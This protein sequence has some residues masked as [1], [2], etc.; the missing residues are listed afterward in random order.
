MTEATQ[1]AGE[2]YTVDTTGIGTKEGWWCL[3]ATMF[4]FAPSVFSNVYLQLNE[5]RLDPTLQD[6]SSRL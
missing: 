3:T 1:T 2:E 5:I 4:Q 6:L